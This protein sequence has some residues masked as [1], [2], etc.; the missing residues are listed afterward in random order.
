MHAKLKK[1]IKFKLVD[2]YS[3]ISK[4]RTSF[5][6]HKLL[7]GEN[8]YKSHPNVGNL[9]NLTCITRTPVYYKHKSWPQVSS[10]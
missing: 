10:T 1:V 9:V 2:Y 7:R 8:R 5:D 6:W 4:M 3:I